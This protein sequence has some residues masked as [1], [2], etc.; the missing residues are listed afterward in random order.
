METHPAI[1]QSPTLPSTSEG[2]A[3]PRPSPRWALF[4]DVDGTLLDLAATP[5]AVVV[6]RGLRRLLSRLRQAFGGALALVSGRSLAELDRLFAPLRLPAAG[7]HGAELRERGGGAV[8]EEPPSRD[9]PTMV[10]RLRAFATTRPGILVEVK[11]TCVAVHYRNAV[12]ERDALQRFMT[13][14]VMKGSQE[15][16]LMR[17]KLV[18]E[19][20]PRSADKGR[21][22]AWFMERAPFRGRIP[23]FIGDDCTDEMGFA[24]ALRASGHAIQV[25]GGELRGGQES[26]ERDRGV[27][28][29]IAA[30]ADLRKWLR[31]ALDALA[32]R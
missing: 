9:L 21:A 28:H 23:V 32:E 4:L 29:G 15:I 13:N 14:E 27:I 5:D 1:G 10:A 22:V 7:Q 26:S 6:P 2:A 25:G 3:L 18:F 17:G 8:V 19:L 20:K 24:A 30:P 16:E 12:Q 11:G 31:G